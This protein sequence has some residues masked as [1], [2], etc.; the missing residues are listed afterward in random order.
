V[1][2]EKREL[3]Y[4]DFNNSNL[5]PELLQI[6]SNEMENQCMQYRDINLSYNELDFRDEQ[7]QQFK[8]S[9]VVL[10]NLRHIL[11]H[12]VILNHLNLSGM[13]FRKN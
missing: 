5:N 11:E 6:L 2:R 4:L 10:Q 12:N 3:Q 13:K 1:L 7:S 8:I 9:Y